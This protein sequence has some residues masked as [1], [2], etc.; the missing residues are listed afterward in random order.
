MAEKTIFEIDEHGNI[1]AEYASQ[2]EAAAA[3]GITQTAVRKS[4]NREGQI[5]QKCGK[6]FLRKY[7]AAKRKAEPE[8]KGPRCGACQYGVLLGGAPSCDYLGI[9]GHRRPVPFAQC[10]LWKEPKRKEPPRHKAT[11]AEASELA[12]II[13]G[14]EKK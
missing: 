2:H 6:G 8:P 10:E 3:N 12:A 9:V 5:V 14:K 4:C 1:T 7:P 11:K 13:M